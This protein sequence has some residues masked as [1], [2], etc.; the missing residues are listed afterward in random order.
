MDVYYFY[1]GCCD[2]ISYPKQE[3]EILFW[4]TVLEGNSLSWLENQDNRQLKQ[5]FLIKL[6]LSS[7]SQYRIANKVR[8]DSF[9]QGSTSKNFISF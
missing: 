1:F 5:N 7:R 8:H 6:Y 3:T 9:Q 2:K 4:L